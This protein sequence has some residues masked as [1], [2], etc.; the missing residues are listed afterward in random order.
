MV[1]AQIFINSPAFSAT[2]PE[3]GYD[4]VELIDKLADEA[5][6]IYQ[7]PEYIDRIEVRGID[8]QFCYYG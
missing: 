7:H 3:K 2:F 6:R 5:L 4:A 1:I 8:G